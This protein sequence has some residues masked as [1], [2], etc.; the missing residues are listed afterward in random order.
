VC[1]F[2][3]RLV[4]GPPHHLSRQTGRCRT[5]GSSC[6]GSQSS[7][8]CRR[9]PRQLRRPRMRPL[10]SEATGPKTRIDIGI[11][12]G[13][14]NA[15]ETETRIEVAKKER[16]RIDETKTRAKIE[17]GQTKEKSPPRLVGGSMTSDDREVRLA[18]DR[19]AAIARA[20]AEIGRAAAAAV[21]AAAIAPA[22]RVLQAAVAT[23]AKA[24]DRFSGPSLCPGGAGP[25]ELSFSWP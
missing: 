1:S 24:K 18:L 22:A 15:T 8:L 20:E 9:L 17:G 13:R 14:R 3:L 11:E 2:V 6:H 10:R 23:E 5:F 4:M 16:T 12:T 19:E 21:E 25:L 7:S